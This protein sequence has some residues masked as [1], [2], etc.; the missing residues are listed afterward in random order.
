MR[1]VLIAV[2]LLLVGYFVWRFVVVGEPIVIMTKGG[3]KRVVAT[4]KEVR[5][6]SEIVIEIDNDSDKNR[7]EEISLSK[8]LAS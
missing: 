7:I 2:V 3:G 8:D 5:P 1:K 6:H 4:V